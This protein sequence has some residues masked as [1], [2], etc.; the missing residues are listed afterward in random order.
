MP[1]GVNWLLPRREWLSV[2]FSMS[3]TLKVAK[4][5]AG[6]ITLQRT[7]V[8]AIH[9]HLRRGSAPWV[10]IPSLM[11]TISSGRVRVF[12][13]DINQISKS[14]PLGSIS[15]GTPV[16]PSPILHVAT[17]PNFFL[18]S[19][20][21]SSSTSIPVHLTYFSLPPLVARPAAAT[22][23]TRRPPRQP[24]RHSESHS[25]C[26]TEMDQRY[27]GSSTRTPSALLVLLLPPRPSAR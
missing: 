16:C 3:L 2:S 26:N 1:S 10:M 20:R 23:S 19:P 12:H 27:L 14:T 8:S 24:P 18:K 15:V 9:L 4:F 25:A 22:P 17:L 7:L 21:I 6:L 11:T 5:I 13:S